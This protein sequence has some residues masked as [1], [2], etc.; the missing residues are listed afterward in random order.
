MKKILLLGLLLLMFAAII[1]YFTN[2]RSQSTL[3]SIEN[4]FAVADTASIQKIF[5]ADKGDKE[6]TLE[7]KSEGYWMVNNRYK[8]RSGSM[9]ILLETIKRIRPQYP[10]ARAAHNNVIKNLA[11]KARKVE[12]YTNV[13]EAPIRTYFIG[14]TTLDR[15]GNFMLM[16]GAE[17]PYAVHIP[18]FVGYFSGRFILEE[19]DWRDRTVFSYRPEEIKS[20]TLAYPAEPEKSFH[21]AALGEQQFGLF[22]L[23]ESETQKP[24]A[25]QPAAALNYLQAYRFLACEAFNSDFTQKDSL[26]QQPKKNILTVE[27]QQGLKKSVD[28]Y[29][30]PVNKRSKTQFD[31]KGNS[32]L[33]DVDR[34]Y[35][36]MNEGKD[37]IL[38][39]NYV[40]G[41]V[42]KT[43]E[44]LLTYKQ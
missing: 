15:K 38:I 26:L 20:I 8:V 4:N 30:M 34:Y 42:L 16:D 18:G 22:K 32:M 29:Y 40:F 17:Q 19:E 7:R 2:S 31:E 24:V 27:N 3:N 12:I 33:Y 37:F 23:G 35:A 39:Q 1:L 21:L 6:I 13:D 28:I 14:G 25:L 11:T 43:Y 10:V 36:I 5:I 41:K 9:N 44:D